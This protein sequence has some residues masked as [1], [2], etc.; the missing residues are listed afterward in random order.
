M[1]VKSF[2]HEGTPEGDLRVEGALVRGGEVVALVDGH[3]VRA[4][5]GETVA[6]A[7]LAAGR[8]V[9]RTTIRRGEPRGVYCG[10]G[11][12][13]DCV[14]TIDG[15]PNIRTCQTPVRAGM[16]VESQAGDGTWEVKP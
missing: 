16:R 5:E 4:F 15:Q 14:M 1:A 2:E 13:F 8:R 7:L 10:I 11:L 9:L 12:C 6:A 3:P